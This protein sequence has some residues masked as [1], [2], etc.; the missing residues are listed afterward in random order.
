MMANKNIKQNRL[1]WLPDDI[2]VNDQST[3]AF[4][5]GCAPYFDVLFSDLGVKTIDGTMGALRLLNHANQQFTLLPNERCCGRD[6]LS[7]GDTEEFLAL[8]Q[9]NLDEFNG[10]GIK[11]VI[12]SCPECYYTL[13]V[14]YPRFLKNWNIKVTHLTEILAPLLE[15]KQVH[16][17][18]I[19]QKVTYQD[20]CTLGSY[21]YTQGYPG[22][23]LVPQGRSDQNQ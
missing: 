2:K 7:L 18:K 17:G 15:T 8:A 13:K 3:T 14:D 4:F 12:T 16:L 6:M 21:P 11:E 1:S 5:V 22:I 23:L 9:S 20:P 19:N 10:R